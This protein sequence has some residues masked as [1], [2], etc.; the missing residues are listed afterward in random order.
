M[1]IK[2][3]ET[4]YRG[5]RFRSR[6]EAR[7]AVFFD[8]LGVRWEYEPQGFETPAGPY[9][10][11]FL[12]PD[13]NQDGVWFEVKPDSLV[14]HD[15]RWDHLVIGTERELIV[16]FGMLGPDQCDTRD[17]GNLVSILPGV[18]EQGEGFA[19][20]DGDREFCVCL[21]C[22]RIG[23]Q[24]QGA[25]GRI[26]WHEGW[27]AVEYEPYGG[28]PHVLASYAAARSARF[29]HGESGPGVVPSQRR[30]SIKHERTGP[31]PRR[32]GELLPGVARDIARRHT[33][34]GAA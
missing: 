1:T 6:L 19:C 26:C 34:G 15:E 23:I 13:V 29:E 24:Y 21:T 28:H 31:P 27:E 32:L 25:Q 18:D 30:P 5:Y 20:P 33:G 9:L 3:I 22:G 12:L 4:E 14:P 16:A 8:Q 10:P 7:W 17:D 2:A 11:D